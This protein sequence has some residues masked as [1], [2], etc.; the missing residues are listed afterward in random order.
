MCNVL[1]VMILDILRAAQPCNGQC[2]HHD[3]PSNCIKLFTLCDKSDLVARP[4]LLVAYRRPIQKSGSLGTK[5]GITV[6]VYTAHAHSAN[7]RVH[8][9]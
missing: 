5:T 3:A 2:R 4:V 9:F 7:V 6:S 8:D 1:R